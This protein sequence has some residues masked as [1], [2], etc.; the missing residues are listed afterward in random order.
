[1]QPTFTRAPLNATEPDD[2]EQLH[3]AE[4]LEAPTLTTPWTPGFTK[5]RTVQCLRDEGVVY[6]TRIERAYPV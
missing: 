5:I 1:V 4:T 6:E 3:V 2:V